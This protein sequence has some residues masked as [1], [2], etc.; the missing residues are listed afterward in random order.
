[1]ALALNKPL[2][3]CLLGSLRGVVVNVLDCDIILV[4]YEALCFDVA[5]ARMNEALNETRTHSYR[6]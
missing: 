3:H 5:Q 6:F 2:N 4:I 1:M